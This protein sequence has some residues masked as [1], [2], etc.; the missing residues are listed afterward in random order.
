MIVSYVPLGLVILFW[1]NKKLKK[2]SLEFFYFFFIHRAH[3]V[4]IITEAS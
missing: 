4:E 1:K 3:S 2:K